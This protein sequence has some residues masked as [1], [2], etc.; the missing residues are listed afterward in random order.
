MVFNCSHKCPAFSSTLTVLSIHLTA[1]IISLQVFLAHTLIIL[2]FI[3]HSEGR[4]YNHHVTAKSSLALHCHMVRTTQLVGS[5]RLFYLRVE[6][7]LLGITHISALVHFFHYIYH[8][9]RYYILLLCA[10][11]NL[12]HS[13]RNHKGRDFCALLVTAVLESIRKLVIAVA[14]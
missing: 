7:P 5:P 4:R 1:E 3:F 10:F 11:A 6:T 12:S 2:Q 14:Q 9:P 13:N 8:H